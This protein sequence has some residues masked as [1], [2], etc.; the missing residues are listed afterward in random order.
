MLFPKNKEYL[1]LSYFIL[2]SVFFSCKSTELVNEPSFM[3]P[4]EKFIEEK[5]EMD[6]T[7]QNWQSI[8]KDNNLKQII[9]KA[10]TYN[11]DVLSAFETIRLYNA[12]HTYSQR[13]LAPSANIMTTGGQRRFGKYTMDGVGN[14][15]TN[16]S[17]NLERNQFIPE[18]L[19]DF[20]IGAQTSWEIDIWGKLKNKRRAALLKYLAGNEGYRW[21]QT[22]LIASVSNVYYELLAN[23]AEMEIVSE[24][25]SL[26]KQGLDII[27]MQKETGRVNALAVDQFEAQ[28]FNFQ[29][30]LVELEQKKVELTNQ[31]FILVG[32]YPESL[33]LQS[34]AFM[35]ETPTDIAYG[36]PASLLTNR[37]DIRQNELELQAT[38]F[39]LKA[40]KAAFF[41]SLNINALVGFHSFNAG[42]LLNPSSYTYSVIGG[43]TAPLFNRADLNL[44]LEFTNV[45]QLQAF[46]NYQKSA[47][48]AYA[49][50]ND[51]I[52][53]IENLKR[54]YDLKFNEANTLQ[55][56]TQNSYQLFMSGRASYIE[57]IIAGKD[58]LMAQLELIEIRQRQYQTVMHLYKA[59]GG[60]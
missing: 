36:I 12:F 5:G 48:V 6:D 18:H 41:P 43:L 49:E 47:I 22:Q 32:M 33:E 15:D 8:V 23:H 13:Q 30:I 14:F 39:E 2:A 60:G 54:S 28:L 11:Q 45:R 56:A 35:E 46:Q 42:L 4:P 16:F 31:L 9:E 1:F 57:V 25:I 10:L 51:C 24:T 29:N 59:L 26:Q 40:A 3:V 55:R 50:V 58:A 52:S 37:P 38:R 20:L 44:E 27:N 17:P 21:L 34:N 53:G 7:L 19:P